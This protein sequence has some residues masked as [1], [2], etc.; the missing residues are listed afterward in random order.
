MSFL[1]FKLLQGT[2]NR[3]KG[4]SKKRWLFFFLPALAV[5]AIVSWRIFAAPQVWHTL[6]IFPP[7]GEGQQEVRLIE[8]KVSQARKVQFSRIKDMGAWMIQE[9]ALVAR[10]SG[11][12]AL[13]YSFFGPIDKPVLL[14][15]ARPSE[16]ASVKVILDGRSSDVSL[17]GPAN[18]QQ[19]LTLQPGYR[20]GIDG[21]V[22]LALV[23]LLD[24]FAFMFLLALIW[25]IQEIAQMAHTWSWTELT[26]GLSSH[27]SYIIVLLVITLA[28]H[29]VNFMAV[30]LV[31]AKDSPS[32]LDGAVQWFQSNNLDGVSSE[33]G[34]GMAMLLIPVL[35]LFG[36]SALGLKFLFHF[37]A[38]ACVPLGYLLG[39][40][41]SGK[42]WFAF[43]AG[44]I[45]LFTPD[46]FLYSN[47]VMSDIP[48]LFFGLLFLVLLIQALN[49]FAWPAVIAAMLVGSFN[50]LVRPENMLMLGIGI[51]FLVA[52]GIQKLNL[53]KQRTHQEKPSDVLWK[54]SAAVMV[55][56]IPLVWWS[57]HNYRVHG[58][59]DL[60]DHAAQALYYGWVYFG[61]S[62]HVPITDPDS[63]SAQII[64]RVYVHD[65]S[66]LDAPT[67]QEVYD[68]L[69]EA[70]YTKE[71]AL[72]I[73]QQTAIDSILHDPLLSLELLFIKF[74]EGFSPEIVA[75]YAGPLPDQDPRLNMLKQNYFDEEDLSV[76][77]L[78]DLQRVIYQVMRFWY[79]N[80]YQIW[81]WFCLGA[82]SLSL[83]RRPFFLWSA[84]GLITAIRILLPTVISLS[85]WRYILAGIIPLQI[86]GLA[87]LFSLAEF[88]RILFQ[89]TPSG[90]VLRNAG[91]DHVIS[92]E[93]SS[94]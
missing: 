70:G 21:R 33:R 90:S 54:V 87:G 93:P 26:V 52:R 62:S 94:L 43:L 53:T 4:I 38:I 18:G 24:L 23:Y 74:R 15:F 55:A 1:T 7:Q 78:I 3:L 85:H 20:F 30:P 86:I 16:N 81:V 66:S 44:L 46:L 31:V 39:W 57:A 17:N 68:A 65:L 34:P 8:I 56:V 12:E 69:I 29:A 63:E 40:Q 6:E 72:S 84:L 50:T 35:W 28:L 77:W 42:R 60:S 10:V 19:L 89:R 88:G 48:N 71:Q 5:A 64:S 32:Y 83:Y 61:E 76:G 67:G 41:L 51:L 36:R 59:F 45:V 25:M 37:F 49:T 14:T 47:M 27:R 11:Q 80:G 92:K 9:D 91:S 79:S 58:F 73:I 75:D 82:L 22:I 13:Y 2:Q